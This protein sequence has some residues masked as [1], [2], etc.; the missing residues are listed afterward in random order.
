M[1]P[2]RLACHWFFV[3]CISIAKSFGS[4][5]LGKWSLCGVC[6]HLI[7]E[8]SLLNPLWYPVEFV[9]CLSQPLVQVRVGTSLS[10]T[11]TLTLTLTLKLGA[12]LTQSLKPKPKP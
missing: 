5:P 9:R 12:T 2:S 1:Q 3:V 8:G 11:L 4:V 7:P 6:A 10:L